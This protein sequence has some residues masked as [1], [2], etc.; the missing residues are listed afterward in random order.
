MPPGQ[1]TAAVIAKAAAAL[2][3]VPCFD[4][5]FTGTD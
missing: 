3:P 5:C 1:I 4:C 2:A